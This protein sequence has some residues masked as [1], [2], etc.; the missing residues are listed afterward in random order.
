MR[1]KISL[2]I[3]A[4]TSLLAGAYAQEKY[5]IEGSVIPAPKDQ[6]IHLYYYKPG[7]YEMN[8]E[9]S[10][11]VNGKFSFSGEVSQTTLGF[12][13]VP[14]DEMSLD[15]YFAQHG[16]LP[17]DQL[18]V[19]LETG[20]IAVVLKN[21]DLQQAVISGT[22]ENDAVQKAR[23]IIWK[24]KNQEEAIS[25]KLMGAGEDVQKRDVI[26]QEYMD[27]AK[28]RTKD[29]GAFIQANPNSLAG[30]DLLKRW[31]DP[32]ADVASATKF[33]GYLSDNLKNNPTA[34]RYA[35]LIEQA[36]KVAI[37]SVAPDFELKDPSGVSHSL[38]EF[39]GKYVLLDFWASWCIPCR[40]ENPNLIKAY[41]AF[42]DKKF[43]IVGISLDGGNGAH[44]KWTGA[45][46]ADGLIWPQL[47]DLEGWNSGVAKQYQVTAI[48][49]NFLLDPNGKILAKNLRGEQLE[50]VL[51][52]Y[53]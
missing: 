40:K 49:M 11:V 27:M 53:L 32:T 10:Q 38:S 26:T 52:K 14:P 9:S 31:V 43:E 42:K 51:K 20:T 18:G 2:A 36:N 33:Y 15:K 5:K 45:I 7:T 8:H 3:L 13:A 28:E 25:Q 30:L 4:T 17:K 37:G 12:I 21:Q 29:V 47:S 50:E 23:P 34:K 1:K 6:T 44:D 35:S 46:K 48:P 41:E 19:Y 24:Y 22:P 39:K 16:S